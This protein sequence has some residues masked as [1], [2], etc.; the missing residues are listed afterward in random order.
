LERDPTG[1]STG[2]LAILNIKYDLEDNVH[3]KVFKFADDTKI[4]RRIKNGTDISVNCRK[5][6]YNYRLG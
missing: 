2:A 3:G 5:I 6:G 4:F 1:L